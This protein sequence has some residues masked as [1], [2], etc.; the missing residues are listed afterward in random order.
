[1]F[2]G[3][4]AFV[5][6]N[7]PEQLPQRSNAPFLGA[8]RVAHAVA[9][10]KNEVR[11]VFHPLHLAEAFGQPVFRAVLGND[12]NIGQMRDPQHPLSPSPARR[13]PRRHR[14]QGYPARQGR[15][16]RGGSRQFDRVSSR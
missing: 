6:K 14:V 8:Q 16:C 4:R 11:L 2:H 5:L 10:V 1:M 12:V 9:A 15:R 7:F 3:Q 13:F